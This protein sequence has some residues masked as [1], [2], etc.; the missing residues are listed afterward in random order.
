VT[1]RRAIGFPWLGHLTLKEVTIIERW[2][3]KY[4]D[5][6][7]LIGFHEIGITKKRLIGYLQRN[8]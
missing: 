8:P 2:R 1:T 6:E 7:L 4:P 5:A 3:K